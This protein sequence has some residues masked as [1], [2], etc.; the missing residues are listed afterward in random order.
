MITLMVVK[1]WQDDEVSTRNCYHCL[2]PKRDIFVE[3][4]R[5]HPLLTTP[6]HFEKSPLPLTF[7]GVIRSARLMGC[8]VDCPDQDFNW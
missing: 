7:N 4:R 3:C 6:G 8:C 1:P 5:G 2:T